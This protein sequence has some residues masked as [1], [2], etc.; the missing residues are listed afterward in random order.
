MFFESLETRQMFAVAG[1]ALPTPD[2]APQPYDKP[3]VILQQ[4][5]SPI[6]QLN[7]GVL[8]V[9]GTSQ[10]DS[11]DV[12]MDYKEGLVRVWINGADFAYP[13]SMV[14][15]L[16]VSAGDGNDVIS[17]EILPYRSSHLE[18]EAGNDYISA[19]G[20]GGSVEYSGGIGR[21]TLSFEYRT[22]GGVRI[23]VDRWETGMSSSEHLAVTD[24]FEELIGT[25]RNDEISAEER[26]G[27]IVIRGLDGRDQITGSAWDDVL[28]G[29]DGDDR[30]AGRDGNDYLDGGAG[31]DTLFGEG[32]NDKLVSWDGE[33]DY[34][35]GGADDDTSIGDMFD[36]VYGCEHL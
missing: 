7:N 22:E 17:A 23:S 2:P 14:S 8:R 30:I 34:C 35:E 24:D 19:F 28:L 12:R 9:N 10:S 29:G 18:G 5:G 1:P 33:H 25:N 6:P 21:D 11:I 36:E 16:E 26:R 15:N 3:T 13:A 31:E 4:P 20:Y 27:G 32:G